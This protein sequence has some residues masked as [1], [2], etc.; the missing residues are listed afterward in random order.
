MSARFWSRAVAFVLVAGVAFWFTVENAAREVTV[1]LILFRI[2]TSVPLV[3]FGSVLVG[4]VTVFLVGLRADLQTR[5]TLQRLRGGPGREPAV[6]KR[7]SVE[8]ERW[9]EVGPRR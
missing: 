1:D 4:M 5:S 2:S 7:G 3:V 8:P 6:P 9:E